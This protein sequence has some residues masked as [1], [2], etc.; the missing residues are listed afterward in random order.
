MDSVAG[1]VQVVSADLLDDAEALSSTVA[2][3]I[4]DRLPPAAAEPA[5]AQEL[6]VSTRANIIRFLRAAADREGAVQALSAPE[7]AVDTARLFVRRGIDLELL[8]NT[9]RWGQ[10]AALQLWLERATVRVP[11][12]ELAGV[13]GRA[14]PL[15]F[16]YVDHVLAELSEQM[17]RERAHLQ[18]GI[19]ARR[20]QT[21]RL[22]LEGA[23]IERDAASR[24]LAYDLTGEHT[25]F[26]LWAEPGSELP[27]GDLERVATAVGEAAGGRSTLRIVPGRTSLWGWVRADRHAEP[28]R[29]Q[30]IDA[31]ARAAAEASSTIRLALGGGHSGPEGFRRSHEEALAAQALLAGGSPT[32]QFVAFPD[33]E[34]IALVGGDPERLRAFVLETLGPLAARAHAAVA[35]NLR[36]YLASGENASQTAALLGTHR[37]TVIGRLARAEAL[38]GHPV[39]ERRLALAVALEADHRLGFSGQR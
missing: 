8:A 30:R 34:V 26:V 35:A 2:G 5:T 18:S 10:N 39:P 3:A 25:A 15:L 11:A 17:E 7:E 38:L 31:I 6:I 24:L 12:D 4:T 9:Y 19:A 14:A 23:P 22:L 13:L 37:N 20:E 21:V 28:G 32:E 27:H 1:W 36:V 33:V 16:A 29:R